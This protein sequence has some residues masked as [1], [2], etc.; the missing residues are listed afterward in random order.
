MS[1]RGV[2][3]EKNRSLIVWVEKADHIG[4][5]VWAKLGELE[6]DVVRWDDERVKE[7][8]S[9]LGYSVFCVIEMQEGDREKVLA[10]FSPPQTPLTSSL[11][12]VV[13]RD[14]GGV[15]SSGSRRGKKGKFKKDWQR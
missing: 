4:E 2:L 12:Y 3:N 14:P 6:I 15:G 9:K 10:L 8:D 5:E 1:E 7:F 13:E 11:A